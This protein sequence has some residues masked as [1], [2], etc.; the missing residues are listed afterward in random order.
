MPISER[1]S[2]PY[3]RVPAARPVPE[4]GP[5]LG[6]F[7]KSQA[8]QTQ[9]PPRGKKWGKGTNQYIEQGFEPCSFFVSVVPRGLMA[10]RTRNGHQPVIRYEAPRIDHIQNDE[11]DRGHQRGPAKLA[12]DAVDCRSPRI[13]AGCNLTA[14]LLI[15]D[16]PGQHSEQ[17]QPPDQKIDRDDRTSA[18]RAYACSSSTSVP[19]KSFGWRNS[20][21]LPCAPIFGSPSPSTRAPCFLSASRALRISGT[22]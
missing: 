6:R 5:S 11:N 10:C 9:P 8:R 16:A 21:G 12:P 22:S 19:Q 2:S 18:H 14:F 20:T 4:C 3:G 15:A 7:S 1:R 17:R 13:G